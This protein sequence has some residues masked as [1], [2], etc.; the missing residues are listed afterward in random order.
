M[1][2]ILHIALIEGIVI[3]ILLYLSKYLYERYDTLKFQKQSQSVKYGKTM[4][5]FLPF[6]NNYPYDHSLFRFLGSP[7]DGVQF[8]ED[9][10]IFVEFKTNTSQ[11]NER[12]KRIKYLIENREVKWEEIRV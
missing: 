5:Q 4:E 12:Q 1:V 8:T 7:I 10:V 9:K 3:L 11:L 6:A 2:T